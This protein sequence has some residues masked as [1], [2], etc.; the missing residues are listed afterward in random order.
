MATEFRDLYKLHDR[1]IPGP[2]VLASEENLF[3]V[4]ARLLLNAAQECYRRTKTPQ[5]ERKLDAVH[6]ILSCEVMDTLEIK[7]ALCVA[8]VV[9]EQLVMVIPNEPPDAPDT[10]PDGYMS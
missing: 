6:T 10:D 4:G 1:D 3:F 5:A 2:Y 8:G 7:E 9:L